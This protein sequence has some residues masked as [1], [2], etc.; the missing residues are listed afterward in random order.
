MHIDQRCQLDPRADQSFIPR[1]IGLAITKL[2]L[3]KFRTS[4]VAISRTESPELTQLAQA[5]GQAFQHYKCDVSVHELPRSSS[6]FTG[7]IDG[8]VWI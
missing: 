2:L 6:Q 1:G 5:H 8:A 4:V 7:L 3:E